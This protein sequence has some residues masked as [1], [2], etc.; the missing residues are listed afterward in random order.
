MAKRSLVR[1]RE[2][3]K[4]DVAFLEKEIKGATLG[5]PS[6]Q[7]MAEMYAEIK[8][9]RMSQSSLRDASEMRATRQ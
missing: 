6:D 4:A 2:Q 5:D 3:I 7:E 8:A 9:R 1:R